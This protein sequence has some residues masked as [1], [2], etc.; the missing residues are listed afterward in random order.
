MIRALPFSARKPWC[1]SLKSPCRSVLQPDAAI[2]SIK[3]EWWF[4]HRDESILNGARGRPVGKP[5]LSTEM[6]MKWGFLARAENSLTVR[7]GLPI[8]IASARTRP[9]RGAF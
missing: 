6:P 3:F 1:Q 5:S 7:F 8:T 9:D 4:K 2:I